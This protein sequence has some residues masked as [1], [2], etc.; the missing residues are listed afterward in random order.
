MNDTPQPG[1]DLSLRA[2]ALDWLNA[3]DEVVA[4][5]GA[6]DLYLATNRTGAEL[7]QALAGGTTRTALIELQVAK[8][9]ID[10][11]RV[12]ADVDAFLAQLEEHG[13]LA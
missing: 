13:L 11:A 8:Y 1:E 4:L 10:A 5:D 3:D 7:W 12:A 2:E 6:R 9:G